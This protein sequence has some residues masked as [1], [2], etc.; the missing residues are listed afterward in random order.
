MILWNLKKKESLKHMEGHTSKPL[1]DDVESLKVSVCNMPN[2]VA[3]KFKETLFNWKI[4]VK[5]MNGEV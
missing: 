1:E 4:R 2:F 5:H 3:S